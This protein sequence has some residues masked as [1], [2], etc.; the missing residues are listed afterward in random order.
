MEQVIVNA[1]GS[2]IVVGISALLLWLVWRKTPQP[3][4]SLPFILGSAAAWLVFGNF[5]APAGRSAELAAT[6]LLA[7]AVGFFL[8]GLIR[9]I[10]A[11]KAHG[12]RRSF[13]TVVNVIQLV[14]AV[15]AM[16]VGLGLANGAGWMPGWFVA[17]AGFTWAGYVIRLM[18][19]QRNRPMIE[20]TSLTAAQSPELPQPKTLIVSVDNAMMRD[21][22]EV[23]LNGVPVGTVTAGQPLTLTVTQRD[24]ILSLAGSKAATCPF[25]VTDTTSE[26]RARVTMGATSPKLSLVPG[27]GLE[28]LAQQ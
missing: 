28:P 27:A 19:A 18:L 13:G 9:G 22:M 1:V 3:K 21:P 4:Q 10:M 11:L 16:G 20:R 7:A 12:Q 6:V 5:A 2:L 25:T 17:L 23:Q 26:G 15:G 24:N 8:V 14:I